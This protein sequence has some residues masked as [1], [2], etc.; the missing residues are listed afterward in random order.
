[1]MR[2]MI[3]VLALSL[4]GCSLFEASPAERRASGNSFHSAY[5]VRGQATG[6]VGGLENGHETAVMFSSPDYN[7]KIADQSG[8]SLPYT[9]TGPYAVIPGVQSHIVISNPDNGAS[10]HL[11]H[12]GGAASAS[13]RSDNVE[14]PL[15]VTGPGR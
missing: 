7:A 9:R 13:V 8:Q 4:G 15:P 6:V 1:M 5:V 3:A 10:T 11:D 14:E 12:L 2:L